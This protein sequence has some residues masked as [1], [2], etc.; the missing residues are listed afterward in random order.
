MESD[1]QKKAKK[2]DGSVEEIAKSIENK[3]SRKIVC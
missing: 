2:G 3:V 1:I